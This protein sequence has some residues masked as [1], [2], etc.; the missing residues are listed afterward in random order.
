MSGKR[1]FNVR[2]IR[3]S[4]RYIRAEDKPLNQESL[5]TSSPGTPLGCRAFR[6]AAALPVHAL[7]DERYEGPI[8]IIRV[9]RSPPAARSDRHLPRRPRHLSS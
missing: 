9:M 5:I 8:R 2:S 1:S 6:G 4:R 3:P 7:I